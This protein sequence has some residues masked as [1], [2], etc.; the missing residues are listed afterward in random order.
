MVGMPIE[1]GSASPPQ[2]RLRVGDRVAFSF[3]GRAIEATVVED[4]GDIGV[5]GRQLVRIR[6]FSEMDDYDREFE[7]P[8]EELRLLPA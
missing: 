8:A 6:M 3:I 5:G 7:M 4:R 2:R 1:P